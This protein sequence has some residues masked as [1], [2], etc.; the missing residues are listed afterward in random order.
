LY[1]QNEKRRSQARVSRRFKITQLKTPLF[2]PFLEFCKS[3]A[4]ATTHPFKTPMDRGFQ[5]VVAAE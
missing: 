4:T 5:G 3:A 2:F 1:L